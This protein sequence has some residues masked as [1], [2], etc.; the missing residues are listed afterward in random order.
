MPITDWKRDNLLKK[1]ENMAF[2]KGVKAVVSSEVIHADTI[3]DVLDNKFRV[4]VR[5]TIMSA[6][7]SHCG[8]IAD[9]PTSG[10][11]IGFFCCCCCAV[12][13]LAIP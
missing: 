5:P 3:H 2:L 6:I 1:S 10:F 8:P 12:A 9:F 13:G 4:L 11:S 7:N